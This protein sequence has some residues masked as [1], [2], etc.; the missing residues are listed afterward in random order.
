MKNI[1]LF[2]F[3]SITIFACQQT[4]KTEDKQKTKKEDSLSFNPEKSDVL[5]VELAD[6]VIEAHGG[7]ESWN[8]TRYI[9][10][11]F[12]GARDL[13]WDKYTGNVRIDFPGQ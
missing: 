12:L 4:E 3:L 8:N 13:I 2:S 10:W 7:I 1:L 9:S 6:K 11:N 5:A